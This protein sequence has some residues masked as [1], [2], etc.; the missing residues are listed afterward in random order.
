MTDFDKRL[1]SRLQR[2]DAAI[3]VRE[4]R[5]AGLTD[6]SPSTPVGGSRAGRRKVVV[7]LAA[8]ALL[9]GVSTVAAVGVLDGQDA[10]P[11]EVESAVAEVFG[12][13]ECVTAAEARPDL[14]AKL[15]A[16][17]FAA[18]PIESRQFRSSGQTVDEA[19]C[20]VPVII[21][22]AV[23][24]YPGA[25]ADILEALELVADELLTDCFTREQATQLVTAA[26]AAHGV[27]GW[28][29]TSDPTAPQGV[30]L[31]QEQQYR[32][33]MENGCVV[34]A[35]MPYGAGEVFLSGEGWP[36]E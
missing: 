30:P 8:A 11:P 32:E 31:D 35:G 20:A 36:W 7:L 14:R 3:P 2:L 10:P 15:D 9:V 29:I 22:S 34:Y 18:W 24:L 26:L 17:G 23:A 6:R 12:E 28:K 4:W 1:R 33:H 13:R 25:G 21:G 5:G 19:R 27:E 16:A